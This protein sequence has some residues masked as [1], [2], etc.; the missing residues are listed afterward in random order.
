MVDLPL[1]KAWAYLMPGLLVESGSVVGAV[2]VRRLEE[3]HLVGR[4]TVLDVSIKATAT[5]LDPIQ[6]PGSQTSTTGGFALS[7]AFSLG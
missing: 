3:A 5:T 1:G 2:P 6:D 7:L 4:A